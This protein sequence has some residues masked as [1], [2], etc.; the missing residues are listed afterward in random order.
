MSLVGTGQVAQGQGCCAPAGV[1]H[2]QG[3]RMGRHLLG[4]Y[5]TSLLASL[6]NPGKDDKFG[7]GGVSLVNHLGCSEGKTRRTGRFLKPCSGSP[8]PLHPPDRCRRAAPLPKINILQSCALRHHFQSVQ[9]KQNS[10][11]KKTTQPQTKKQDDDNPP[12][13]I[14]EQKTVLLYP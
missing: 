9:S 13:E 12:K 14:S 1:G 10:E 7:P 8:K 2:G 5:N 11:K 4:S 3:S 6:H